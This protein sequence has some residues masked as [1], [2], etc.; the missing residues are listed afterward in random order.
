MTVTGSSP[1]LAGTADRQVSSTTVAA[2]ARMRVCVARILANAATRC[3]F[4]AGRSSRSISWS[5]ATPPPV[6]SEAEPEGRAKAA[7][8][9]P[10][11]RGSAGPGRLPGVVP[12]PHT[13]RTAPGCTRGLLRGRRCGCG[14]GGE[15][16]RVPRSA[17][18]PDCACGGDPL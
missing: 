14:P 11:L 13:T 9:G 12:G 18:R 2:F 5:I 17:A 1:A 15:D 7:E 10:G 3:R 6:V 16:Y 8:R 4:G